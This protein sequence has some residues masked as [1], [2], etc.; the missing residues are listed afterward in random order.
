MKNDTYNNIG[1]SLVAFL[2]TVRYKSS[3]EYSKALLIQPLLLHNPLVNYIK[4][5][6]VKVKGIE[7]L[8]LSKVN[9]FLNFNERYLS[10]MPLGLN[11]IAIAHKMNFIYIE[12]NEI[13]MNKDEIDKFDFT[14]KTLGNRAKN[15][16]NASQ[17]VSKLLNEETSELYF[18]LRIQL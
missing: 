17:K 8:T 12:N 13:I 2:S 6:N 7:D 4:K 5:T 15:I 9:Y 3:I 16:I 11:T 1:I 10:F 18:K 14:N